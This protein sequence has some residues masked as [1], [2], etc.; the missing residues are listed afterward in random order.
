MED[1]EIASALKGLF[2]DPQNKED[3]NWLPDSSSLEIQITDVHS[4][5]DSDEVFD[6]NFNNIKITNVSSLGTETESEMRSLGAP[7][8]GPKLTETLPDSLYHMPII[9]EGFPEDLEA[10][11]SSSLITSTTGPVLA[12]VSLSG[13]PPGQRRSVILSTASLS[14]G[15]DTGDLSLQV[16]ST[17]PVK[18]GRGRPK[19]SRNKRKRGLKL[20]SAARL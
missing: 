5:V 20:V 9:T 13:S 16:S 14:V 4:V 11:S 7:F 3:K 18:R 2:Q 6:R 17:A 12:S 19:G 8:I 15:R 1:E 10:S